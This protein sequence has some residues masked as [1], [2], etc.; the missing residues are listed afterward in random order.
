LVDEQAVPRVIDELNSFRL[1][2]GSFL[3]GEVITGAGVVAISAGVLVRPVD[4]SFYLW[5]EVIGGSAN[6]R[7]KVLLLGMCWL[8]D[9]MVL[10]GC[11]VQWDE[12]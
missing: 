12:V 6:D 4:F 2:G 5:R 7:N 3:L 9:A 10:Q 8:R 1:A 11:K